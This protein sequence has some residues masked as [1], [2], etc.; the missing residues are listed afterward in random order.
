[1]GGHAIQR[2]LDGLEQWAGRNLRKYVKDTCEMQQYRLGT[3]NTESSFTEKE[4]RSQVDNKVI[5]RQI[6]DLTEMKTNCMLT[7]ISNCTDSI[8]R[9]REVVFLCLALVIRYVVY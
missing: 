6:S 2:D 9:S 4:P 1:M 7:C 3:K 5:T 8:R